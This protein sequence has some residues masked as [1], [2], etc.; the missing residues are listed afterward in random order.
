MWALGQ[1]GTDLA[2]GLK[3]KESVIYEL[4]VELFSILV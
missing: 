2:E 4:R 1:A 3:G